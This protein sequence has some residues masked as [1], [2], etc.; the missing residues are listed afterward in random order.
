M[1]KKTN[2]SEIVS[3][4]QKINRDSKIDVYVPSI[5]ETRKFSPLT[6]N[7]QKRI[8]ECALDSVRMNVSNHALVANEILNECCVDT[9]VSMYAIDRDPVLISLR[10]QT[11]GC[12]ATVQNSDG[13]DIKYDIKNHVDNFSNIK[14]PVGLFDQQAIRDSGITVKVQAPT[15][16]D[17]YI[18]NKKLAPKISTDL[19]HRE[20]IK[21]IIGDAIIHE[22][23][24]YIKSIQ[25]EDHII[26]FDPKNALEFI[27]IVEELPMTV[28]K[29]LLDIINKIKQYEYKFT[30]IVTENETL[31]IA[32]D[33][34]FFHSE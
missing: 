15:L 26:V 10:A 11:I 14:P 32:T 9:T 4:I 18:I 22:Y 19:Q 17:D 3:A 24:K 1:T 12:K 34:R 13:D 33:A 20:N 8:I 30:Q 5:G 23:V 21:N 25:V 29:Q 7:H 2:F 6:V 16:A 27:P 31:T 28:S